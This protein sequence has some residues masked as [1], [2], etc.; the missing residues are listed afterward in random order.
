MKYLFLVTCLYLMVPGLYGDIS[1]VL[2]RFGLEVNKGD[3]NC[4]SSTLQKNECPY[5]KISTVKCLNMTI[6]YA[7]CKHVDNV[8][9]NL[10]IS[11][12]LSTKPWQS[13]KAHHDHLYG[14]RQRQFH[15][16]CVGIEEGRCQLHRCVKDCCLGWMKDVDGNCT[17]R[18][19]ND[20]CSNGGS[21]DWH[22]HQCVCPYGFSGTKCETPL[23][24][25]DCHNNGQCV[26]SKTGERVCSCPSFTSGKFCEKAICDL[27]CL[28]GLCVV[29][30][31]QTA[32]LCDQD[33]YG[34]ACEHS[35]NQDLSCPVPRYP[36]CKILNCVDECT[37]DIDCTSSHVCCSDGCCNK[38]TLPYTSHLCWHNGLSYRQGDSYQKD[39]CTTC[40]CSE[41]GIW[42]CKTKQCYQF[43]GCLDENDVNSGC[44]QYSKVTIGW[45]GLKPC[46]TIEC[47]DKVQE[48]AVRSRK[49]IAH[50]EDLNIQAFDFCGTQL[51]VHYTPPHALLLSGNDV[52]N[53]PIIRIEA[54]TTDRYGATSK[55]VQSVS[56]IDNEDPVFVFCPSDYYVSMGEAVHWKEPRARDN[57]GI[58]SLT[59]NYCNGDVFYTTTNI[60]Y[61][62][63]DWDRKKVFCEFTV[64]VRRTD[65]ESSDTNYDGSTEPRSTVGVLVGTLTAALAIVVIVIIL[66]ILFRQKRLKN[67]QTRGTN[68]QRR[69]QG[70][71]FRQQRRHSRSRPTE[72][73]YRM[74]IPITAISNMVYDSNLTQGGSS[75]SHNMTMLPPPYTPAIS[76]PSYEEV[77]QH[78]GAMNNEDKPPDYEYAVT[79]NNDVPT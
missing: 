13:L 12:S 28:N 6:R 49:N 59:S 5:D 47:S 33:Y 71:N 38:C 22:T 1:N 76:P 2:G 14:I 36:V 7:Q 17:V 72:N 65:T 77:V 69:L 45:L 42:S 62:A 48:V 30:G 78:N 18:I 50:M 34:K 60:I 4:Y 61:A 26:V 25:P 64:H 56:V 35:F 37:T 70:T 9:S 43:S 23:C 40:S 58:M 55:C 3:Q 67:G 79:L 66:I 63:M 57:V 21:F 41:N 15:G 73:C 39:N 46:P 11:Q 54:S 31:M 27:P 10:E 8:V 16:S 75:P 53:R 29:D 20:Y 68:N 32:C 52:I 24:E 51:K 44:C 19:G 74:T